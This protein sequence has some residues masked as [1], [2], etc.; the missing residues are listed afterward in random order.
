MLVNAASEPHRTRGA[1]PSRLT[2]GR[3]HLPGG[4]RS[5]LDRAHVACDRCDDGAAGGVRRGHSSLGVTYLLPHL[6]VNL[7]RVVRRHHADPLRRRKFATMTLHVVPKVDRLLG[8]RVH[9]GAGPAGRAV[10]GRAVLVVPMPS[11]LRVDRL[12]VVRCQERAAEDRPSARPP[13]PPTRPP[14]RPPELSSSACLSSLRCRSDVFRAVACVVRRTSKCTP[15]DR[16][17]A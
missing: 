1:L 16:P 7:H 2:M 17:V 6:G 8:V 15:A 13:A 10:T 3:E 9:G 11:G 14:T 12:E 4:D 5:F